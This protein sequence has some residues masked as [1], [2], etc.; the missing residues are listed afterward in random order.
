MRICFLL[1]CWQSAR[2]IRMKIAEIHAFFARI[3]QASRTFRYEIRCAHNTFP[4]EIGAPVKI[5][6]ISAIRSCLRTKIICG[7]L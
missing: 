3:T 4:H 7:M 2:I 6:R 5:L 1:F